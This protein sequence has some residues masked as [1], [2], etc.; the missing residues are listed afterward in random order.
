MDDPV[1]AL[2][3]VWNCN[4][5]QCLP[6][7][8]WEAI[9]NKRNYKNVKKVILQSS[10][11]HLQITAFLFLD[12]LELPNTWIYTCTEDHFFFLCFLLITSF[13]SFFNL[14][15]IKFQEAAVSEMLLSHGYVIN[16]NHKQLNVRNP[17]YTLIWVFRWNLIASYYS[18]S[19]QKLCH[20]KT[21]F[22]LSE[23]PN[24]L[25]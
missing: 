1:A 12:S 18:G 16:E 19:I 8:H 5:W 25:F 3:S 20:I 24:F 10:N 23:V 13:F 14:C 6:A 21:I 7:W 17:N 9:I 15:K 22:L 2:F 4:C 11:I